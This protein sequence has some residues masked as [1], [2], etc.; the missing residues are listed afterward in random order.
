LENTSLSPSK[1][2][3]NALAARARGA[4]QRRDWLRRR[5]ALLCHRLVTLAYGVDEL[6]DAPNRA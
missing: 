6:S 1:R 2:I 5:I 4:S 3:A